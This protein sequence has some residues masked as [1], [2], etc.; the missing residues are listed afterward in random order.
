MISVTFTFSF[1]VP[2]LLALLNFTEASGILLIPIP[3]NSHV[4]SLNVI[5]WALA[6]RGHHVH[7]LLDV[8]FKAPP[9]WPN[10]GVT[11]HRYGGKSSEVMN[12]EKF[13]QDMT[14]NFMDHDPKM[15]YVLEQSQI[16]NSVLHRELLTDNDELI[17]KLKSLKLDIA[18]VDCLPMI[19][20]FYLIPHKL[21]IPWIT[22]TDALDPSMVPTPWLPSFYTPI[23]AGKSLNASVF[24]NRLYNVALMVWQMITSPFDMP[25]SDKLLDEYRKFKDF[26]NLNEL[27]RKSAMFFTTHNLAMDKIMPHTANV[28]HVGG[29]TIEIISS[30]SSSPSS[31]SSS[32]STMSKYESFLSAEGS[33]GAVLVSFGSLVSS[34]PDRYTKLFLDVFSQFPKLRFIWKTNGTEPHSKLPPNVLISDWLPQN[35]LLSRKEVVLFITHGGNNG[36]FEALYHGVPMLTIPLFGDQPK[37]AQRIVEKHFGEMLDF[38]KLSVEEMTKKIRM[39]IEDPTY[40]SNITKASEIFR[41]QPQSASERAAYWTE[42]VIKYGCDHLQPPG[43]EL[44]TFQYLLLDVILLISFVI[45]FVLYILYGVWRILVDC[46]KGRNSTLGRGEVDDDGGH[47]HCASCRGIYKKV[48]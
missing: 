24:V 26:R 27:V 37:N 1:I 17:D 46:W 21:G 16:V 3:V 2:H 40:K 13:N 11:Y 33:D 30:S 34:F 43:K 18:V 20:Y 14:M 39:I 32:P 12:I 47:S 10:F 45:F 6:K 5:G 48:E 35:Q 7:M 23:L 22:Y 29:L 9:G 44:F 28:A 19:N 15:S 38:R 25:I 4:G 41:S 8:S 36:Q 31:S 42:H